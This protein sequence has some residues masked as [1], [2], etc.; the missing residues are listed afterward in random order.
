MVTAMAL[1]ENHTSN[2]Q[3]NKAIEAYDQVLQTFPDNREALQKRGALFY[4][5]GD[6]AAAARDLEY[7]VPEGKTPT[8]ELL[9]IRADAAL[10][11]GNPVKALE[12]LRKLPRT[13]S[14]ENKWIKDKVQ[15][16]RDTMKVL[17]QRL[18]DLESQ[19]K[20]QPKNSKKQV[21]AGKTSAGLGRH[22][23]A[24]NYANKAL[25]NNPKNKEAYELKVESQVAKGDVTG[26]EQ[27]IE[28]A[29]LN[30]V[31]TKSIERWRPVINK[32]EIPPKA[33][34]SQ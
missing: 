11:S 2:K 15:E 4:K 8:P 5:K 25:K 16:A 32:L 1:A 17:Q 9:K 30:G 3:D 18:D 12:D 26:A 13:D 33:K 22:D 27:T 28:A 19:A 14:E 7:A 34:T 31:N 21:E 23:A 20:A 6:Y 24:L 29:K 10:K